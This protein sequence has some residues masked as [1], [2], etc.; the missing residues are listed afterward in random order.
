MLGKK[1]EEGVSAVALTKDHN[2]REPEE[3]KKL[4]AAHPSG[5]GAGP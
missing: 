2:I 1:S 4:K 5:R 3:L